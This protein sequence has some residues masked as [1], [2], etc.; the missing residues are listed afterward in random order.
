MKSCSYGELINPFWPIITEV[1]SVALWCKREKNQPSPSVIFCGSPW[2]NQTGQTTEVIATTVVVHDQA[3]PNSV[4]FT[5]PAL[6]TITPSNCCSSFLFILV[7]NIAWY[8]WYQ[9]TQ[10]THE[11]IVSKC[12]LLFKAKIQKSLFSEVVHMFP[13]VR[14]RETTQE[15]IVLLTWQFLSEEHHCRWDFFLLPPVKSPHSA[16]VSSHQKGKG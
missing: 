13:W 9:F 4:L 16:L 8:I 3:Q 14:P 7:P 11:Q 1:I 2:Y 5:S 10:S 15:Q 12:V 6:T